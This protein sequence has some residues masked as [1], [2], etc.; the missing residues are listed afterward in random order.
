MASLS[1]GEG[2]FGGGRIFEAG[3]E[4]IVRGRDVRNQ[5]AE[6]HGFGVRTKAVKLRR[7]SLCNL[8][9]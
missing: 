5:L 6:A 4:L 9:G 3:T 7:H 8:D 2:R 1:V